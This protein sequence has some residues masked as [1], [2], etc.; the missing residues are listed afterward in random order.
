MYLWTIFCRR[1][2][3]RPSVHRWRL[4]WRHYCKIADAYYNLT[5][6]IFPDHLTGFPQYSLYGVRLVPNC[7]ARQEGADGGTHIYQ[8]NSFAP[9]RMFNSYC[10]DLY[11]KIHLDHPARGKL[12][13][14]HTHPLW[15]I[16]GRKCDREVSDLPCFSYCY[17]CIFYLI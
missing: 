8:N 7:R 11:E 9:L 4:C 5:S 3:R 12:L 10:D 16:S 14:R 6:G 15:W 1:L 13:L 2:H 17:C